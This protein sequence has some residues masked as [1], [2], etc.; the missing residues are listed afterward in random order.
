MLKESQ[1]S[2]RVVAGIEKE[3]SALHSLRDAKKPAG[4]SGSGTGSS[5]SGTGSTPNKPGKLTSEKF[6]TNEDGSAKGT[7]NSSMSMGIAQA[8]ARGESDDIEGAR[9]EIAQAQAR[10][11]DMAPGAVSLRAG[12]DLAALAL[13]VQQRASATARKPTAPP[14]APPVERHVVTVNQHEITTDA[15]GAASLKVMLDELLRQKGTAR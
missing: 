14:A 10:F 15:Q 1:A 11:S 9:R 4:S 2:G 7:F 6:E 8:V 5:G 3:R 13:A 12:D